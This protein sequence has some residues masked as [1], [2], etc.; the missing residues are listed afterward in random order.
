[1][2]ELER[3]RTQKIVKLHNQIVTDLKRSLNSAI[4]IGQLLTD[5]KANL[6]HGEFTAWIAENL[7]FSDRTARNYMRVYRERDR[8][9]TETV[10]DLKSAY[11]VLSA[12]EK[13]LARLKRDF[14]DIDSIKDPDA[15]L[16]ELTRI[17][18]E[19][20]ELKVK[21]AEEALDIEVEIG[22]IVNELEE[23]DEERRKLK[24]DYDYPHEWPVDV[25]RDI[26]SN[27][28]D[29]IGDEDCFID[30]EETGFIDY[31]DSSDEWDMTEDEMRSFSLW[32][33][34]I[35]HICLWKNYVHHHGMDNIPESL[36]SYF[37]SIEIDLKEYLHKALENEGCMGA[38]VCKNESLKNVDYSN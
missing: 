10:S 29:H 4:E 38:T 26:I 23:I 17:R 1:M 30:T 37:H 20:E 14:K 19:A 22:G 25:W 3:T 2:N 15:K 21:Y 35:K 33:N 31:L 5:Q 34:F 36:V 12:P 6:K 28:N 7:P 24:D 27:I 8:L 18:D 16:T 9:K 11:R 13:P 32:V